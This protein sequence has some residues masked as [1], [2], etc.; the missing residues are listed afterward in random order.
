V[1]VLALLAQMVLLEAQVVELLETDLL[2]Q[3]V[4]L[5]RLDK[6]LLEVTIL[7]VFMVQ[8]AVVALA[9]LDKMLELLLVMVA[10]VLQA[11]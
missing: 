8:Q 4:G 1:V 3:L 2:L 9:Q 11:L 5:Q 7:E 6:V 10:L